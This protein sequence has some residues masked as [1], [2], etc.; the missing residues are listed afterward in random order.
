MKKLI[1][2]YWFIIAVLQTIPFIAIGFWVWYLL[3][4]TLV[5]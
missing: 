5:G 4:K 2:V 3:T 1:N